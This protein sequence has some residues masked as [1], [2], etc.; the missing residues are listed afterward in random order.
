MQLLE[1]HGLTK[2]RPLTQSAARRIQPDSIESLFLKRRSN[3]SIRRFLIRRRAVIQSFRSILNESFDIRQAQHSG[4][5]INLVDFVL[6]L[7]KGHHAPRVLHEASDMGRLAAGRRAHVQHEFA[8]LRIEKAAAIDGRNVL[9]QKVAV[10]VD[11]RQTEKSKT[12]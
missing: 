4:V 5:P 6:R 2:L 7:V 10:K 11:V 12:F 8:G 9:Q 1:L 3:L